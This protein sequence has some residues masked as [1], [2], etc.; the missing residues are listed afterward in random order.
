MVAQVILRN[1]VWQ[2]RPEAPKPW[3]GWNDGGVWDKRLARSLSVMRSRQKHTK[4]AVDQAIRDDTN[5]TRV[6][7]FELAAGSSLDDQQARSQHDPRM[8][9][10]RAISSSSVSLSRRACSSGIGMAR[11]SPGMLIPQVRFRLVYGVV[12]RS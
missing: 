11:G 3:I 8:R 4:E 2:S 5:E 7:R 10:A 1:P 12:V 6:G 9:R